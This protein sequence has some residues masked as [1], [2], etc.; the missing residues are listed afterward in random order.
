MFAAICH[1]VLFIPILE[2]AGGGVP[3]RRQ[4]LGG[5][6]AKEVLLVVGVDGN[7]VTKGKVVGYVT[8]GTHSWQKYQI[9]KGTSGNLYAEF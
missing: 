7:S 4:L 3:P 9:K 5:K 1:L 6:E 8:S 2:P